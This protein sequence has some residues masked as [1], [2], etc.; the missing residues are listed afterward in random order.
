ME[1]ALPFSKYNTFL[2]SNGVCPK[3]RTLDNDPALYDQL[4]KTAGTTFLIQA[5]TAGYT[6]YFP[7][8]RWLATG[9]GANF[10][11]YVIPDAIRPYYGEHPFGVNMF[12]RIQLKG[13]S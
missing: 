8:I 13:G 12:L 6:R 5:Y 7:L 11:W 4:A 10:T 1:T 9:I 3:G 2:R